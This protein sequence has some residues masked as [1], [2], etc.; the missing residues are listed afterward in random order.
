MPESPSSAPMRVDNDEFASLIAA[1]HARRASQAVFDLETTLWEPQAASEAADSTTGRASLSH[2][3]GRLR[4][5]HVGAEGTSAR[6]GVLVDYQ[7]YRR[8]RDSAEEHACRMALEEA[9]LR[10]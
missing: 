3:A 9:S 2:F 6:A 8:R 1:G 5:G 10:Q 7:V 4:P